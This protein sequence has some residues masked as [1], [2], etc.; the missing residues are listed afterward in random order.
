[1]GMKKWEVG[2]SKPRWGIVTGVSDELC[3]V[4]AIILACL[5]SLEGWGDGGRKEYTSPFQW[6]GKSKNIL[7]LIISTKSLL[8]VGNQGGAWQ[9]YNSVVVQREMTSYFELPTCPEHGPP[10]WHLTFPRVFFLCH[11]VNSRLYTLVQAA[12]Q[13]ALQNARHWA[14]LRCLNVIVA[15]AMRT[16]ISEWI[17]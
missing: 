10:L 2:N 6:E 13:T 1:M 14:G 7:W 12:A 8:K 16:R 5:M 17:P 11:H 3:L 9:R 15:S 4:R